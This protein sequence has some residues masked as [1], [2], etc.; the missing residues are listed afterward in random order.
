MAHDSQANGLQS[1]E[2]LAHHNHN[3]NGGQSGIQC[4]H[5]FANK[6]LTNINIF[7][8]LHSYYMSQKGIIL[9]SD[10]ITN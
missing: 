5:S 1:D 3:D 10:C 7:S 4:D 8:I 2:Q 9:N 6:L